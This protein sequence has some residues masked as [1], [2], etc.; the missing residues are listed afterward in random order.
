MIEKNSTDGML[1]DQI[2]DCLERPKWREKGDKERLGWTLKDARSLRICHERA[3]TSARQAQEMH[4]ESME[5]ANRCPNCHQKQWS[6]A[7]S[8]E[9]LSVAPGLFD[10]TP[11]TRLLRRD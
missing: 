7:C 8:G 5:Q 9:S 4:E 6:C 3:A 10:K 2:K 11:R 1:L